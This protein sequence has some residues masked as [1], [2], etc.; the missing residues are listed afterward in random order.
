MLEYRP[1]LFS[2]AS[3]SHASKNIFVIILC[4]L[5]VFCVILLLESIVPA[6][7]TLR[8]IMEELQKQGYLNSGEVIS[9]KEATKL[10]VKVSS[11]PKIMI[12]SLLSTVFGT[13]A[14]IFYCRCI[15][16]RPV[17]SMGARKKGFFPMY[18]SG[19][20]AG[21]IMMS[22]IA[23]I[24]A[25]LGI[26]HIK[27]CSS[28][29]A[30]VLVLFFIGFV[31]QGMS[32][33][34]IFRGYLMTTIGG[35]GKHTAVAVAVS[36]LG[37]ALAHAGN[38]GFGPLPFVNL[39][40]FG[41]FAALCVI[42]FDNIWG[43]CAIHSMWNFAQGNIYGISVSGTSDTE[44]VFRSVPNSTHAFLTGGEF[45]IEGSLLTTFI[46]GIGIAMSLFMISKKTTEPAEA[47]PAEAEQ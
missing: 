30:G 45:G 19:L 15:E 8:P 32:E 4:F 7:I 16:M 25:C 44:S 14:S 34:F 2:E 23:L 12:P 21:L 11:A 26:T 42:L 6:I 43:A 28:I 40:L 39:F 35:S 33:E 9:V 47:A 22:F 17:R 10:A 38:P 1:K 20:A 18:L 27:L 46:L 36:S 41:V 31:V 13:L 3:K 37:F 29:N 5:A 24:S